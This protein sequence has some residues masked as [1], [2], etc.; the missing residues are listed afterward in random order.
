MSMSTARSGGAPATA[1]EPLSSFV[2]VNMTGIATVG[3]QGVSD[4]EQ[5][6]DR[7]AAGEMVVVVHGTGHRC[8]GAVV[9]AARDA[10]PEAVNFLVRKAGGLVSVALTPERCDELDLTP[11][12]RRA[13]NLASGF[14]VSVEAREGIS[15]GISA[16]DRARTIQ[17]LVDP[18]STSADLVR[19]GHVFPIRTHAGGVLDRRAHPEAAV[20]LCRAA[21]R[22]PA[23]V[24]CE[25][26]DEHGEL[27][28]EAELHAFAQEHELGLVTLEDLARH[29]QRHETLVERGATA[30]LPTP[31]GEFRVIGYRDVIAGTE[32]LALIKGW[33]AG[34]APVVATFYRQCVVA[35][36]FGSLRCSCADRLTRLMR[37]VQDQERGVLIY[38]GREPSQSQL[39]ERVDTYEWRDEIGLGDGAVEADQRMCDRSLMIGEQILR[40]LKIGAVRLLEQ[41]SSV[42]DFLTR[43]GISVVERMG[44]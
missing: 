2:E 3:I 4:A 36:A 6:I 17:V 26:L 25:I 34:N 38:V 44:L 5:A 9:L 23:G 12:S 10:S 37:A 39:L 21:G 11:M 33:I 15:T 1:G 31:H 19:P 8:Q 24:I 30:S 40:D 27:A 14:T 22:E 43:H 16:H 35:E 41:D 42:T 29:R 20:D 28:G 18:G 32:H 13:A 7:I